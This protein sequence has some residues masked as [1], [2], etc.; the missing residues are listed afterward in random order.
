MV[1]STEEQPSQLKGIVIALLGVLCVS[2]DA[3]IMRI[4]HET[5]T[6]GTSTILL[7]K[8]AIKAVLVCILVAS[9]QGGW[10]QAVRGQAR[11]PWYFFVGMFTGAAIEISFTN[12]ILKTTVARG[13]LFYS[14]NPMWSALIGRFILGDVLEAHTIV[15]LVVSVGAIFLT[16]VPAIV[17]GS[18]TEEGASTLGDIIAIGA[19]LTQSAYICNIRAAARS[20]PNINM[21][22][23]SITGSVMAAVWAA[24]ALLASGRGLLPGG[25]GEEELAPFFGLMAL[26]GLCVSLLLVALTLAPRHISG[27]EVSLITLLETPLGPF[28]VFLYFGETPGPWTLGGGA[29]LLVTLAAHE[30]TG[31]YARGSGDGGNDGGASHALG[32][33]V[34]AL[35]S[36]EEAAKA[37]EMVPRGNDHSDMPVSTVLGTSF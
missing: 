4:V 15:A 12:M 11:G 27:A 3:C 7:W 21:I 1:S 36:D 5:T 10:T 33:G 18:G 35:A 34:A 2:P 17:L 23:A 22:P 14:L 24:L 6:A 16:F 9:C 25:G 28:I 26:D 31:S 20:D 29:L 19:G 37:V 13:M 8:A 32:S 30:I